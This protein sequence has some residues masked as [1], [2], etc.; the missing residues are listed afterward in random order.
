[1]AQQVQE[2]L[3]EHD[4][5]IFPAFCATDVDEHSRAV[6]VPGT[7]KPTD[8]RDSHSGRVGSGE[9][10]SVFDGVHCVKNGT[11]LVRGQNGGQGFGDFGIGDSFD[12]LG[13]V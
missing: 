9:D 12:F 4:A 7:T 1:L 6:D 3:A 10:G 8:L 13:P 11:D 2:A 5:A